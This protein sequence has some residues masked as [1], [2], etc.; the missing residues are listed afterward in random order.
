MTNKIFRAGLQLS[1]AAVSLSILFILLSLYSYLNKGQ[2]DSLGEEMKLIETGLALNGISYLE[3]L[4]KGE[5]RITLVSEEGK[6]LFDSKGNKETMENHLH[7]EEIES[8]FIKG[9]GKSQRMSKT[10]LEKNTYLAKKQK[11]GRVLRLS[12]TTISM[13]GLVLSLLTE[14]AA[15]LLLSLL[16]A[17]FL[18]L[19]LAKNIV[20]PINQLDLDSPNK[21]DIYEEISPLLSRIEKQRKAIN[22]QLKELRNKNDE[23]LQVIDCMKEGLILLDKEMKILSFNAEAK[24]FFDVGNEWIGKDFLNIYRNLDFIETL[25]QAA[26]RGKAKYFAE[27][28]ER[29]Y[30]FNISK[31]ESQNEFLGLVI[32]IFDISERLMAEQSRREF[33]ANVSHELR[34]PLQSIM[35]SAELLENGLV[36]KEDEADFIGKIRSEADRLLTLIEDI[37]KLS[38]LDE[39][40][41]FEMEAVRPAEA[42]KEVL[43]LLSQKAQNAEVKLFFEEWDSVAEISGVKQMVTDIIYNLCENGIKYNKKGGEVRI[44]LFEEEK[45]VRISIKD[46]GIGIP[47]EHRDRVFER[48]YCVDKSRSK[49]NGG[50][51]LGL[52]IVKHAVSFLEGKIELISEV[53]MGT[54]V[55]ISLPKV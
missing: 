53:D 16:L 37:I 23:F 11:D 14:I 54:E 5:I 38:H 42:I 46:T 25:E 18:S 43:G 40:K 52:A 19:R 9:I 4:E 34:T 27:K 2:E 10:L 24:K 48:F 41:G 20:K 12:V 49:R 13:G 21:N 30:Q 50:T 36:R 28:A 32:V 7:R 1:L 8:A 17:I 22:R 26:L 45:M 33:S 51:G 55:I 6:I 44:S 35:G 3:S 29:K 31:I 15:V 47:L 39:G